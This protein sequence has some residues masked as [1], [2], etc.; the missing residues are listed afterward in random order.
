MSSIGG[1]E[2]DVTM[3]GG[4]VPFQRIAELEYFY[5]TESGNNDKIIEVVDLKDKKKCS[6]EVQGL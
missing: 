6:E 2:S 1:R 4:I 3:G 5:T